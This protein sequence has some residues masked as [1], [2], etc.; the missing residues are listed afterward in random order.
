VR[1]AI[2][3]LD[4]EAQLVLTPE[5]EWETRALDVFPKQRGLYPDIETPVLEAKVMRGSFYECQGG[6]YRMDGSKEAVIL[7]FSTKD[8][9]A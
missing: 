1:A 9:A 3:I 7:R 8:G 4:A 5:S 6:W 2:V